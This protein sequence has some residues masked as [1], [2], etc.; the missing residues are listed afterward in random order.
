VVNNPEKLKLSTLRYIMWGMFPSE[1]EALESVYKD[2]II[3]HIPTL[4]AGSDLSLLGSFVG[5]MLP[6]SCTAESETNLAKLVDE[7]QE[8]KPQVLKS[9]KA[10]H[11]QVGRCLKALKLLG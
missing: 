1:Q 8:M 4:N 2:K 10:S 9:V 3:A 5:S 6:A 7:Y 11:Q